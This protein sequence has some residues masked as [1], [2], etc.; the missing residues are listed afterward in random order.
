[1]RVKVMSIPAL[2]IQY[3]LGI[4]DGKKIVGSKGYFTVD[5]VKKTKQI[6]FCWYTDNTSWNANAKKIPQEIAENFYKNLCKKKKSVVSLQTQQDFMPNYLDSDSWL[7]TAKKI[8]AL[9]TVVTVDTA[10]AHLAGA[11]G[12]RVINLIGAPEYAGWQYFPAKSD[13][14][15]WYDSMELIWYDPYT[16]WEAGLDEALKKICR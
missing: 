14:T 5:D 6:G 15:P 2:L 3:G 9:D 1:M 4:T 7:D 13:K 8:K 16:N 10:V 12:V 11:L